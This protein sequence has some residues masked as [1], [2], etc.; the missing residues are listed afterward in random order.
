ML[1]AEVA[2]RLQEGFALFPDDC[3]FRETHPFC[4]LELSARC[5]DIYGALRFPH[6]LPVPARV[7]V[8]GRDDA[9]L[10]C[11]RLPQLPQCI[12]LLCHSDAPFR[13]TLL[14]WPAYCAANR[15]PTIIIHPMSAI[16]N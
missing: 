10:G 2:D 9:E 5:R 11:G 6:P 14:L 12:D 13:M 7:P 4:F 8:A 3:R 15:S 16:V 1:A